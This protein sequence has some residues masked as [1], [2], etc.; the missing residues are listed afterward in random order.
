VSQKT[1]GRLVTAPPRLI[2]GSKGPVLA[3]TGLAQGRTLAGT[4]VLQ[5]G[6]RLGS[7]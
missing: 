3:G 6:R 2:S 4:E 5:H 1:K 7:I